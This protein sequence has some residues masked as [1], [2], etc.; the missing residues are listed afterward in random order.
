MVYPFCGVCVDSCFYDASDNG[1]VLQAP[2]AVYPVYISDKGILVFRES[3]QH[4]LVLHPEILHQ[5]I[6]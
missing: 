4:H 1:Y 3:D 6:F 5:C 2:D